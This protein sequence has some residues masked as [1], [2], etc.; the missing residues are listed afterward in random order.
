M[1]NDYN[2]A[3]IT[4]NELE[5]VIG[6]ANSDAILNYIM[7]NDIKTMSAVALSEAIRTNNM[8]RANKCLIDMRAEQ[9]ALY[10]NIIKL[11]K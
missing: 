8:V 4:D 11:C 9:P 10:N 5:A 7:N 1:K 2:N 3:L 6:G